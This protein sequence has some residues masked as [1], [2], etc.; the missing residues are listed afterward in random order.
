MAPKM[1]KHTSLHAH[2][3]KSSNL[4][5]ATMTP[6]RWLVGEKPLSM[7]SSVLCRARS[8]LET[9]IGTDILPRGA[10][11]SSG[12]GTVWDQTAPTGDPEP[13][14]ARPAPLAPGQLSFAQRG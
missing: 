10:S 3:V 11:V 5:K 8:G 2:L 13:E 7:K 4:W 14:R 6:M 12:G 9:L 1:H